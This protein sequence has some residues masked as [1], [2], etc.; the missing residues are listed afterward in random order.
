MLE[1]FVDRVIFLGHRSGV[2]KGPALVGNDSGGGA[3]SDDY[4]GT[5]VDRWHEKGDEEGVL[6]N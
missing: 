5:R 6:E 1:G 3:G 2:G 4:G